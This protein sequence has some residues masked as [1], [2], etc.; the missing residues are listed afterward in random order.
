MQ[1][2]LQR[3]LPWLWPFSLATMIV[4]ASGRSEVA[5]P[6]VV[7]I[8]KVAHFGVFGLLAILVVRNGFTPR[9]AWVAVLAVSLFG[10]TDEWHQSVTPGRFV[11]VADWVADTLGAIVAVT[12]Y[13]RWPRARAWLERPLWRRQRRIEKPDPLVP[14]EAA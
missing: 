12:I 3:L 13:V 9:R 4:I 5:A 1:P 2:A 7:G 14:N 10:L 6:G 11:E 8:D